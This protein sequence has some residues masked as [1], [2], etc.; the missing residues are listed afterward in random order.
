[1][2]DYE[3]AHHFL[4]F[5]AIRRNRLSKITV[6]PLNKEGHLIRKALVPRYKAALKQR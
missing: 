6:N 4:T 5:D 1:M 2:V 3:K